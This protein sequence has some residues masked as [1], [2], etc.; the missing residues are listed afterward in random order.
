MKVNKQHDH[1]RTLLQAAGIR[2]TR[3]RAA[4]AA[5]LFDGCDKHMTAEQVHA[6]A[7][8][9][10]ANMS[11]ATV[12]NTLHQ[13]T[14][15]GLLHEV[16]IDSSRVYFDT[17]THAHHHFFDEATGELHDIPAKNVHIARLPKMPTG[18]KLDR[19]DVIIRLRS[20][21]E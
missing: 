20:A 16:M 1:S 2:P 12:Y 14:E 6:A 5:L 4:L 21:A 17:N 8:K 18:R 13:F 10:K 7:F 19:V 15:A 11:L 9:Q 3:Q